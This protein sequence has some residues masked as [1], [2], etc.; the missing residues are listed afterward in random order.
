MD[1]N[2]KGHSPNP[3]IEN[4]TNCPGKNSN[5]SSLD[6]FILNVLTSK[7]GEDVSCIILSIPAFIGK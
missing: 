7:S 6:N 4:S 3:G 5:F 1:A 2:P